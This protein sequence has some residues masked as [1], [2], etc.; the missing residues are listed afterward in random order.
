MDYLAKLLKWFNPNHISPTEVLHKISR[1]QVTVIDLNSN[2]RWKQ[3]HVPG[4]LHVNPES[5]SQDDLPT[6]RSSEVIFY[7]SNPLCRK[8]PNAAKR[9]SGMGFQNVRVMS[10]GING[11]ISEG[12]PIESGV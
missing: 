1:G 6:D 8:A 4:A 3:G 11:W 10:A 2:M 7:C 9:A 5:M 12:L